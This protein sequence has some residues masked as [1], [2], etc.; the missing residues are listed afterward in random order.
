MYRASVYAD[1]PLAPVRVYNA[2]EI[3]A[4]VN[5]L[6]ATV[7]DLRKQLE[8]AM[9]RVEAADVQL[10]RVGN[11]EAT[12]GRALALSQRIA[13]GALERARQQAA[14]VIAKANSQAST[15]L[16]EAQRTA[17]S[18]GT[19]PGVRTAAGVSTAA[20]PASGSHLLFRV[21]A[22][23]PA[24]VYAPKPA[25]A[26][27]VVPADAEEE[28][29]A[30]GD[31]TAAPGSR[32]W[33]RRGRL[34][35]DPDDPFF[36]VEKR[37]APDDEFFAGLRNALDEPTHAPLT[38][39]AGAPNAFRANRRAPSNVG[40]NVGSDVGGAR[41]PPPAAPSPAPAAPEPEAALASDAEESARADD[42]AR[43]PRWAHRA[44]RT[45][46]LGLLRSIFD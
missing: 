31:E 15:L 17:E 22:P 29:A 13:D 10:K 14:A 35:A 21:D 41:I 24:P 34:T 12:V 6:Q 45:S 7:A 46:T 9:T 30:S 2:E 26:A 39:V 37:W 42:L 11:A 38:P 19:A 25:A 16:A 20:A 1:A 5:R 40:S 8:S 27:A 3:D 43:H 33:T 23:T 18:V 28:V 36:N 44:Q 4:Y 32:W